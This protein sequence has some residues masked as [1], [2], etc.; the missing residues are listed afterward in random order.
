MVTL[1]KIFEQLIEII[2]ENVADFSERKQVYHQL[3]DVAVEHDTDQEV[4][5]DALDRD[6][7]FDRAYKDSH[8]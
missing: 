5:E 2:S 7:A 4:F 1:D 8:A 6:K 3:I